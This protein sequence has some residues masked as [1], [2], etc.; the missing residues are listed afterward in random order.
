MTAA[1]RIHML[2]AGAMGSLFGFLLAERGRRVTLIDTRRELLDAV[3]HGGLTLEEDGEARTLADIAVQADP[4]LAG[5]ADMV[6]VFVKAGD[7]D[8]AVR[9]V[10]PCLRPD[11]LVLTLQNGLGN[12]EAVMRAVRTRA[13][14]EGR[15]ALQ[16]FVP[17]AG[18][19]ACG[20]TM[21]VPGRVRFAGRGETVVGALDAGMH[22][23]ALARLEDFCALL[24]RAGLPAR[25]SPAIRSQI[26]TKLLVNA[27]INA[28][29][30]L[31]RVPNGAMAANP[32]AAAVLRDAVREGMAVAAALGIA[33]DV[34]DP[35]AHT[36]RI[37]EA[38][39]A[40]RSSM[41]Q[42]ILAGRP[43]EIGVINGAIADLAEESGIP[44][45]V[46]ATLARLVRVRERAR[47]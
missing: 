1:T 22:A 34:P 21:L 38:T 8:A 30:A 41:L 26:W 24:Q 42:D 20:A 5:E 19:T 18:V 33:L 10:F 45:P 9:S 12:G 43:T 23:G 17:A 32:E 28:V 13:A 25:I 11:T 27:G 3:T 46:N 37:A 6:L 7:T 14:E 39:A 31:C 15:E 16:G 40:N 47:E 29:T 36:M 4:A 2:G 35:V 44:A